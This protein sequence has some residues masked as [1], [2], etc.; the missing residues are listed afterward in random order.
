MANFMRAQVFEAIISDRAVWTSALTS[1]V[2]P[3]WNGLRNVAE[4][5]AV[6]FA[7]NTFKAKLSG[8]VKPSL[9]QNTERIRLMSY[10]EA[11]C[12][13]TADF[14]VATWGGTVPPASPQ[15]VPAMYLPTQPTAQPSTGSPTAPSF[16]DQ[17]AMSITQNPSETWAQLTGVLV[18]PA[19]L[20]AQREHLRNSQYTFIFALA[21]KGDATQRFTSKA[22]RG[23]QTELGID[24]I[25]IYAQELNW[26]CQKVIRTAKLTDHT[27]WSDLFDAVEQSMKEVER[28]HTVVTWAKN[29]GTTKLQ[30]VKRAYT[31]FGSFDWGALERIFHGQLQKAHD[32]NVTLKVEPYR[33]F[34]AA[35]NVAKTWEPTTFL[36]VAHICWLLLDLSGDASVS[37]YKGFAT[38]NLDGEEFWRRAATTYLLN[39]QTRK[40]GNVETAADVDHRVAQIDLS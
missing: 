5:F 3:G 4:R 22:I 33:A 24:S 8:S 16:F 31:K 18:S 7:I 27:A 36:D 21:K 14:L 37:G 12:A 34:Y 2:A 1:H 40:V 23:M 20:D 25:D 9:F 29:A 30:F 11:F 19:A 6:A 13:D 10:M 38:H 32:M 26:L 28:I 35:G 39:Y 15:T 17:I